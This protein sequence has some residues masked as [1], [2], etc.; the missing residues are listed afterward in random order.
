LDAMCRT[1]LALGKPAIA[2][3]L[4]RQAIRL[5]EERHAETEISTYQVTLA[6]LQSQLGQPKRALQRLREALATLERIGARR[7]LPR[8]YLFAG[9]VCLQLGRR[10]EAVIELAKVDRECTALGYDGILWPLARPLHQLF[11]LG[12]AQP[13]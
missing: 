5:A 7:E 1:Y 9:Q 11:L 2:E 10:E 8:A 12:A 13:F 6:A 4:I 3:K